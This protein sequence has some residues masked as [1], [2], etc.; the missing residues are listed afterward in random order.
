MVNSVSLVA[1]SLSC[2]GSTTEAA[3]ASRFPKNTPPIGPVGSDTAATKE[4]CYSIPSS[5]LFSSGQNRPVSVSGYHNNSHSVKED[6]TYLNITD[7]LISSQ[8][9]ER[10]AD[11]EV[12][13][14]IIN[15]A[16]FCHN[17]L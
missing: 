14:Q 6:P 12:A 8:M 9:L 5:Y 17:L 13:A 7:Q 16:Q 15:P 2:R 4:H 1:G 10:N 11:L 3:A